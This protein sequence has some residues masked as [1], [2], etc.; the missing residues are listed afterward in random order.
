VSGDRIET[1]EN[2]QEALHVLGSPPVYDIQIPGRH[3]NSLDHGR[4]H[5]DH[6]HLHPRVSEKDEDLVILRLSRGH[7]EF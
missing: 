5:A 1:P 2:A 7:D 3:R 6:D 4:S